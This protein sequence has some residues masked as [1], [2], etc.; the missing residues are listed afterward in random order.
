M[1]SALPQPLLPSMLAEGE[2]A[3]SDLPLLRSEGKVASPGQLKAVLDVV[4]AY[5]AAPTSYAKPSKDL[6]SDAVQS[7]LPRGQRLARKWKKEQLA[8]VLTKW[9]VQAL[10]LQPFRAQNDLLVSVSVSDR[11]PKKMKHKCYL[12][13]AGTGNVAAFALDSP[14][15][16]K[17]AGRGSDA[18]ASPDAPLVPSPG[19]EFDELHL[20]DS[21]L[22]EIDELAERANLAAIPTNFYTPRV[23]NEPI[24][25]NEGANSVPLHDSCLSS[26][27]L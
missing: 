25:D 16:V 5:L 24:G 8:L 27:S 19:R 1:A 17:Q 9:S 23:F 11:D 26:L 18:A 3:L 14:S 22:K 10:R 7:L 20:D 6:L 12:E 13:D 21:F 15:P 4:G 2:A